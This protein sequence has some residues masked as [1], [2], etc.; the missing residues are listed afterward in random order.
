MRKLLLLFI[1]FLLAVAAT[2]I[3]W[4]IKKADVKVSFSLPN[5]NKKGKMN[6]LDAEIEFDALNPALSKITAKADVNSLDMNNSAMTKHL[7][8]ADYFDA[9]QYPVITFTSSSIAKTD[10]GFSAKGEL[11]MKGKTREIEIPFKLIETD[12]VSV[13]KG[14]M[15]IFCGDFNVIG[16][17]ENDTSTQVDILIEVPVIKK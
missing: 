15:T 7:L 16:N 4:E 6:G 5:Q 12:T 2:P 3:K 8:S 11:T 1:P 10:S 13:F 9:K 14:N 17:K